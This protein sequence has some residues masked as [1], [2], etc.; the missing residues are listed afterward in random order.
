MADKFQTLYTTGNVTPEMED[1]GIQDFSAYKGSPQLI[2]Q[3]PGE[4]FT[5][6]S[7]DPYGQTAYSDLYNLYYGGGFDAAQPDFVTPPANTTPVD[8]GGGDAS[9]IGTIPLDQT[10]VTGV[11]TPF[12]QNLLDQGAGV[13]AEP[14]APISAPGEG[15]LTQ[16]AI[17]DLADYP[18]NTEYK[19]PSDTGSANVAEQ[20][21]AN[22]RA[23]KA[24]A[25]EQALINLEEA[26]T[27]QANLPVET[28]IGGEKT[29]ADAGGI[30]EVGGVMGADYQG[31]ETD[32]F[33]ASEAA[34]QL[35]A[36][37]IEVLPDIMETGAKTIE[38]GLLSKNIIPQEFIDRNDHL[39]PKFSP[40]VTFSIGGTY[41]AS[42]GPGELS[43]FA[44]YSFIDEQEST[45][46][47]IAVGKVP[48]QDRVDT[49]ITYSWA[50]YKISAF[51]RNLTDEIVEPVRD[52]SSLMIF[53]SP[54]VGKVFGVNL[55]AEF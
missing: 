39:T 33:I 49:S 22:Q 51:G 47:N 50:N 30:E 44:K 27:G 35:P 4:Q 31:T 46:T 55:T 45:T 25:D 52:I 48:S 15:M 7:Y 18:V 1:L 8:T 16:Q 24:R 34:G 23:D 21:Y 43:I 42:I 11:N 14:G 6:I 10:G 41:T 28:Y 20:F 5:D 54:T 12:E 40:E 38:D 19:S 32:P 36:E 17:D 29:L 37:E 2:S 26:R 53:G 9:P 3:V 13:Q